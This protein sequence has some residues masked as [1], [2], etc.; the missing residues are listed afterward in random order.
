MFFFDKICL[1][2]VKCLS[3]VKQKSLRVEAKK[4]HYVI[5]K[6]KEALYLKKKNPKGHRKQSV[7][8]QTLQMHMAFLL[9]TSSFSI[10][11]DLTYIGK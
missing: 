8:I 10:E 2:D 9:L 5:K 3:P 1:R 11:W 6:R 7:K 4:P